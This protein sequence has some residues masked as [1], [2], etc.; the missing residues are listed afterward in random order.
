[1]PHQSALRR[2]RRPAD[3][4]RAYLVTTCTDGRKPILADWRVAR[5]VV[6]EMRRLDEELGAVRS[7][8]WVVMPDHWHW[9]LQLNESP[10]QSFDLSEVMRA[11][12]G[13]SALEINRMLKRTGKVWQAG[14]H[15]HALREEEDLQAIARYVIANPL[16]AGLADDIG[17]FPSWDTAWQ[18]G[19]IV[20]VD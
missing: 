6:L 16:R 5:I 1:M 17:E 9:L 2:G 19:D 7:L 11:A 8:A 4:G 3:I 14:Y 13:R 15:D 18:V 10:D 20:A 12:K